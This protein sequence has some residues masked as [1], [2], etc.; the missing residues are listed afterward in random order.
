MR[1]IPEILHELLEHIPMDPGKRRELRD[2]LTA[3]VATEVY[4]REHHPDVSRET[5]PT[6]AA[7]RSGGEDPAATAGGADVSRET[8][9]GPTSTEGISSLEPGQ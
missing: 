4:D 2:D 5:S 9:V 6:T 3:H 7:A 8:S 1:T